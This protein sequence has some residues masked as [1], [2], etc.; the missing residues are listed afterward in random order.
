MIDFSSPGGKSR[1]LEVVGGDI[2]KVKC[3]ALITAVNSGAMWFGGIDGVIQ[4]NAGN[5]FHAQA[6]AKLPLKHLDTVV[7]KK[8]KAHSGNFNDVVFVIDDLE[9]PL[10]KV[11]F[12][13][14]R[15]ASEAGYKHVSIPTIRMGVMSGVV[16][17]TPKEALTELI[18]GI[19]E[20][21]K[22]YPQSCIEKM[23]FVVYNQPNIISIISSFEKK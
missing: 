15:A 4:R 7:A 20:F 13:A 19:T 17:K 16:E 11:I 14:L 1:S 8:T 23:T 22:S 10:G 21:F 5:M 6:L 9:G 3:D 18:K 12:S 2:A